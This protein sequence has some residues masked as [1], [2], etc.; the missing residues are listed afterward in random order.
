M[1]RFTAPLKV[2]QAFSETT[3]MSVNASGNLQMDGDLT[4][5]GAST[6][7]AP[8]QSGSA[9]AVGR[10]VL[11][12]QTTVVGNT[13]AQIAVLPEGADVLDAKFFIKDVFAGSAKS[14]VNIIIGTSA[15]KSIFGQITNA[16]APGMYTAYTS[17]IFVSS[18]TDWDGL[19]GV[20]ATIHAKVT[21][22]SGAVASTGVGLCSIM[23]VHKV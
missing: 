20:G 22:A 1:T 14:D 2:K 3:V 8:I 5:D 10:V 12:Q 17:G 18:P 9:A 7:I 15:A 4:V 13:K 11:V 21:A 23:Y 16:T 19:T 6:F